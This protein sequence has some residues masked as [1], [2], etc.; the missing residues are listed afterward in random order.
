LE[1]ALPMGC[2]TGL[3]AQPIAK[4]SPVADHTDDLKQ[5]VDRRHT[6]QSQPLKPLAALHDTTADV[7]GCAS[8]EKEDAGPAFC[9]GQ[10]KSTAIE[11]AAVAGDEGCG[12]RS[13][14]DGCS[15]R[16]IHE[17]EKQIQ[18]S[19][20]F[21]A[22][23]SSLDRMCAEASQEVELI[24]HAAR[25]D[26]HSFSLASSESLGKLCRTNT[27]LMQIEKRLEEITDAAR[28]IPVDDLGKL[29]V[30]LAQ[31]ESQ[32]Q[33]L[34]GTGVDDVYTGE[35]QSGKLIAKE[36]KKDMLKRFEAIYARA[37]NIFA[38]IGRRAK[39]SPGSGA[40]E[41]ELLDANRSHGVE[42]HSGENHSERQ[43]ASF[44]MASAESLHRL[45]RT[46]TSL[47]EIEERVEEIAKVAQQAPANQLGALK[48]ELAQLESLAQRLEGVGL[49]DVYTGELHSGQILAKESKRDML[50][51]F[52]AVYT[53]MDGIFGVIRERQS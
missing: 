31:L 38:E 50:Q 53:R 29:K 26:V 16:P 10:F 47:L 3:K 44:S 5:A 37:D 33:Q 2:G 45:F 41:Q 32:A 22:T 14:H 19:H 6:G 46:N 24:Q 35:L 20:H 34:E 4:Y 21:D 11:D 52:E 17:A 39:Q 15:L 13:I 40:I 48:A 25:S 42:H 28:Q 12:L 43:K 30:E 8:D 51:R 1:R 27:Q 7:C 36:S 18:D 23:A 49:D 9:M